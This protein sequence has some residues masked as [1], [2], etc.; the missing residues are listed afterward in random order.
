VENTAVDVLREGNGLPF[1]YRIA[2]SRAAPGGQTAEPAQG[3]EA[4]GLA[5]GQS[6]WTH[7][8]RSSSGLKFQTQ[9]SSAQGGRFAEVWQGVFSR[10]KQG[11]LSVEWALEGLTGGTQGEKGSN[12]EKPRET[13]S[14]AHGSGTRADWPGAAARAGGVLLFCGEGQG[15]P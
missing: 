12:D 11:V 8:P 7:D 13:R 3:Q 2:P 4:E 14:A 6:R 15:H 10:S 1:V 9:N 5:P